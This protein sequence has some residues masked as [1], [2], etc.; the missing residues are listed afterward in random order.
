V[1][2]K[3]FSFENFI[4]DFFFDFLQTGDY[5][6]QELLVCVLL[7][8]VLNILEVREVTES[9]LLGTLIIFGL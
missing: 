1:R 9:L 3:Q 4:G 5:D 8:E 2:R 6:V 7:F